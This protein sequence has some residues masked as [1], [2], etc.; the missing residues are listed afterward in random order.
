MTLSRW[1]CNPTKEGLMDGQVA[2]APVVRR[3]GEGDKRWFFGGGVW[4]WKSYGDVRAGGLHV[5]EV[6]M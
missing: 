3:A 4:T 6:E 2:V 5:V 1:Y